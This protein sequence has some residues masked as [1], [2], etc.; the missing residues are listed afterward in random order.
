MVNKR[1]F[2][3]D[4]F[5]TSTRVENPYE[6]SAADQSILADPSLDFRVLNLIQDPFNDASVSYFHKSIGGYHGA[7]LRRYQEIIDHG[8]EPEIRVFA[9]SMSTDS[10][11]VINMLNTKY[12]ILPGSDKQ[13]VAYPNPNA[14]G[15]AWFVKNYKVV[16]N[17]DAEIAAIGGLRPDSLAVIH[18]EFAGHLGNFTPATDSTDRISLDEYAPNR[19]KYSYS[20]KKQGLA[21]FSEIYYPKGWTA[22]LDGQPTPHFRADYVLRAMVLPAGNHKLEFRFEPAVYYTGEKISLISSVALVVLVLAAAGYEFIR[23]KRS[24]A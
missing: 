1:Y 20:L 22:Y 21:V 5:T 13:P 16:E 10:T 14:L 7:K 15:N 19:L 24:G 6:P 18:K 4:S 23:R 2:G 12:F 17:A 8:I 3:N 11:P 9:R